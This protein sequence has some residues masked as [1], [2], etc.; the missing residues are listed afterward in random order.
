MDQIHI[1][2]ENTEKGLE[3]EIEERVMN[4]Y[5]TVSLGRAMTSTT[6]TTVQDADMEFSTS[7]LEKSWTSLKFKTD[8]S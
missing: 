1:D 3:L 4:H 7:L 8:V 6:L 2:K 5:T